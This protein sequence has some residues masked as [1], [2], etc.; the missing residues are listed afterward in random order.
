MFLPSAALISLTSQHFGVHASA[1]IIAILAALT[2]ISLVHAGYRP[3]VRSRS[4][5][6]W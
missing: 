5:H 1:W 2:G 4:R 6:L 3:V